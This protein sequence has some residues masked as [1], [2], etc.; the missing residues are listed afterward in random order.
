MR[1]TAFYGVHFE[2]SFRTFPEISL[3]N[4]LP[5]RWGFHSFHLLF[6]KQIEK[7]WISKKEKKEKKNSIFCKNDN[8]KDLR[9]KLNKESLAIDLYPIA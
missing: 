3:K 7:P 4:M 5:S 1:W 8:K 2:W 9:P 6:L